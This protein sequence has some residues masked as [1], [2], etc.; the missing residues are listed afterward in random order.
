MTVLRNPNLFSAHRKVLASHNMGRYIMD[1]DQVLVN[2]ARGFVLH[3]ELKHA[4]ERELDAKQLAT[5]MMI[6]D[7]WN[8]ARD[9]RRCYDD[10]GEMIVHPLVW[11]GFYIFR[12]GTSDELT[13]DQGWQLI[14][15]R[16]TGE[17]VQEYRGD[18]GAVL[19]LSDI[20]RGKY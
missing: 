9:I 13:N 1:V 4:D 15:L 18:D 7:V 20:A 12:A 14:V 8:A 6:C 11:R 5:I 10:N 19:A 2:Y 17:P 16:G 3:M